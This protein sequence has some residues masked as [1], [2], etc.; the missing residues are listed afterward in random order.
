MAEALIR[1]NWAKF[2][3]GCIKKLDPSARDKVLAVVHSD[4]RRRIRDAPPLGWLPADVFLDL[5]QA[6]YEGLGAEEATSYWR[7]NLRRSMEQPFVRPLAEGGMFLFGRSPAGLVRRTPHTWKLV[8][9]HCGRWEVDADD[10]ARWATVDLY[11]LPPAFR[12]HRGWVQ[13]IEG[14]LGSLFDTAECH[15]G[16]SMNTS[17]YALGHLAARMEWR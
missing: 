8:S 11:E 2:S 17:D 3:V 15:G 12:G 4:T 13:V 16:V 9:R 14:G 5:A 7:M 10:D 1:A 6:V